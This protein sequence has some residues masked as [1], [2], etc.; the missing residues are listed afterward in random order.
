MLFD[1]YQHEALRTARPEPL[2]RALLIRALGLCGEAGEVAELIKKAV[3][4]GHPLDRAKLTKEIGD[5]FWYLATLADAAGISLDVC[6]Q[7]NVRKLRERY[8]D[9]FST[10]A[11]LARVD[12][13][14]DLEK[15]A[16]RE[17]GFSH[18]ER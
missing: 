6:A 10:A 9:G 2:D 5:V 14:S 4:H 1:E 13:R 11:S 16:E 3:G 7:E 15:L 8:P 18:H 12:Q 17:A